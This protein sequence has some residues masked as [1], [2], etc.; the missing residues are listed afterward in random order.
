MSDETKRKRAHLVVDLEQED[1]GR[2][3]ADFS[4]CWPGVMAYG[5]T[6]KEALR[7]ALKIAVERLSE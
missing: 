3:L 4:S 2:W 5:A 6:E 7:D 1:D